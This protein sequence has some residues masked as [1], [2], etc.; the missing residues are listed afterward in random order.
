MR[1]AAVSDFDATPTL[2]YYVKNKEQM[3]TSNLKR[4]TPTSHELAVK[5]DC[6]YLSNHQPT[7]PNTLLFPTLQRIQ[8]R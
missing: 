2:S 3:G 7:Y 4:V 6:Q 1:Q 8:L 5:H